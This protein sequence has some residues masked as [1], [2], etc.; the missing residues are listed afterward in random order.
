MA[1]AGRLMAVGMPA[2]QAALLGTENQSGLVGV[3]A[4]KAVAVVLSPGTNFISTVASAGVAAFILPF[5]EFSA[6]VSVYNG[7]ASPALVFAQAGDVINVLSTGQ[8]FS[9]T[10]GK[11]A[12]FWPGKK[13][14]STPPVNAW[15]ANLSA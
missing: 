5:A 10:N 12:L 3:G 7:G 9:V 13:P 15:T 11:S 1:T 4:T 14:A 8:T 6:P 2:A